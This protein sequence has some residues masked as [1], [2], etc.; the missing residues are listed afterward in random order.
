ML[1]AKII[2]VGNE[3]LNGFTKDLNANFLILN[4]LKYN[5]DVDRIVF[6]KDE[7]S[8]IIH[9]LQAIKSVNFVFLTGGLGPTIDD[10]TSDALSLFFNKQKPTLI[11]NEIGTAP[12]LWYKTKKIDYFSF[13]GVP[14]EMRLMATNI[15]SLVFKNQIEKEK[16]FQVNTIGIKEREISLL[17][18]NFEKEIPDSIKL[19]Y[20]P[21]NNIVKLRFYDSSDKLK[22]FEF[23]KVKL[24]QILGSYIFSYGQKSLQE[25]LVFNLIKKNIKIAVAE[26][27]TGGEISKMLTSIPGSS[28]VFIGSVVAY[29]EY[30]KT[31]I[32]GV[33]SKTIKKHSM[34]SQ[35][36]V[37]HMAQSVREKFK[38]DYGLA[39]TGYM[40]PY[41][42]NNNRFAWI[43][44]VSKGKII[45]KKINLKSTRSNNILITARTI[46][47]E[48]RKEIL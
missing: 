14:S 21:E 10:V 27:C 18:K 16:F 46:L 47:N 17:L 11:K 44:V 38:S 32:L 37:I 8:L 13:P 33:N 25:I 42:E 19:S 39:T 4:L 28:K 7:Q 20:L 34:V 9:E 26:S 1:S 24:T 2:I 35:E 41:E 36:V 23:I 48:L 6:I 45:S 22:G 31:T 3:I 29:S 43:C 5:I 12:G 30:S 40:G 15:F